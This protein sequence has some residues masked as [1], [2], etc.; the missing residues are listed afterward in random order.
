MA[1]AD[2]VG[3]G[4]RSALQQPSSGNRVAD[5]D[6]EVTGIH[7]N[8]YE[9]TLLHRPDSWSDVLPVNCFPSGRYISAVGHFSLHTLVQRS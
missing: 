2:T 3:D 1:D 8:Y 6:L 5:I 4:L 7:I 9:A